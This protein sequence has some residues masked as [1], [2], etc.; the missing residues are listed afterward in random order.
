MNDA[1][2]AAGNQPD[3]RTEATRAMLEAGER[4]TRTGSWQWDVESD[5]FCCSPGWLHI[6]GCHVPPRSMSEFEQVMHPD[7]V[8]AVRETLQAVLAG[9]SPSPFEHRIIRRGEVR[10]VRAHAQLLPRADCAAR[11][12]IGAIQDITGGAEAAHPHRVATVGSADQAIASPAADR[13]AEISASR[14]Q[15]RILSARLGL[16]QRATTCSLEELLVATLDEVCALTGSSLGFYHFLGADQQTLTLQAWSTQTSRD[17]CRA[18]GQ[19]RHYDVAEAGVWVECIRLRCPVMHNDYAALPHRR[20]LPQG[21]ATLLRE[22]VVPIFRNGLIVAIL[23]VGNKAEPYGDED[24]TTVSQ[25]ADLAWDIAAAKQADCQIR[26]S[27]ERLSGIVD[28]ALDAIVTVD[29][30][31][32][33]VLFNA[34][35]EKMFQC[36][37]AE[38]L[39]KSLDRFIPERFRTIHRRQVVDFAST[40]VVSRPMGKTRQVCGVRAGGEEF[41]IEASISQVQVRGQ[42]LFTV[43]LRDITERQQ[44]QEALQKGQ[45]FNVAVIDSLS[46]HVAVLD[47]EGKITAVNRAWRQFAADNGGTTLAAHPTGIDYRQ[48]CLSA[49]GPSAVEALAAWQ[50]IEAVLA[51]HLPLFEMEYT[52]HSPDEEIWFRMKVQPLQG[53]CGGVVVTHEDVTR[54]RR[55]ANSLRSESQR[56][57]NIIEGTNVGTWEWNVQT[58]EATVNERW[59]GIIGYTLAE[60]SPVSIATWRRFAHPDD[61]ER[62]NDLAERHFAGAL[63][64]YDSECR[65]RHKHGHWV[66]VRDRGKV[67]DWTADGKPLHMFGTHL[68]VTSEKLAEQALL[69]AIEFNKQIIAGAQEG[70]VVY[71][72]GLRCQVWNPYL[73][74]LTGLPAQQVIGSHPLELF[75]FLR[76]TGSIARLEKALTGKLPGSTE[77]PFAVSQTGRTGWVSGCAAPLHDTHGQI[78]G[79]IATVRDI[80][81]TKRA[82]EA[83]REMNET[84]E[85]RVDERTRQLAIATQIAESAN[86]AKSF[87]LANMSHEI[88]TPMTAILGLAE[89]LNLDGVTTRQAERLKKMNHAARHL[90]GIIDDVLDLSKIEAG[91]LVLEEAACDV[92]SIV[93][94]VVEITTDRARQKQIAL[95]TDCESIPGQLRGDP[96]RIRQALLNYVSNAIR[97]TERGSVTVRVRCQESSGDHLLLRF[98]VQ[99]TGIGIAADTIGRLFQSFEQADNSMTREYGGTGLGLAIVKQIAQ[100]M[101]GRAGVE[102]CEGTGSTFWF[103]ARLRRLIETSADLAGNSDTVPAVTV[104]AVEERMRQEKR[105]LLVDDERINREVILA[106]LETIGMKADCAANGEEAVE[107]A[108]S[109]SYDLILMDLQMPRMDGLEATRRIRR[110]PINAQVPVLALT[111]NVSTDVKGLCLAAGMND[112]IAKPFTVDVLLAVVDHWLLP[113]TD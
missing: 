19:G 26:E 44:A 54:S 107:L 59:A 51:G 108:G 27:Q 28:A 98:E 78:I 72:H 25:L 32:R 82:A 68:D 31:Y 20:G 45:A 91:K 106:I 34:A 75:P 46:A 7:D 57:A 88:R 81:E 30:A 41:P 105:I 3:Y 52:C 112:F 35:A 79:V 16:M 100:M 33:I 73:E 6:H 5:A 23:G 61:L 76:E 11:Q 10:V 37:A 109:L 13:I 89:L 29:E 36:A 56:L 2:I 71:D 86:R 99:D 93:D 65:M 8:A 66:W 84:L 1:E 111:G 49:T 60:I 12:V 22:L 101:D 94:S 15:E 18:E 102:S 74:N 96:I 92:A 43:A 85:A 55:L 113:G 21:H 69:E 83:L 39:G 63:T 53:D 104:E 90:L 9:K 70:I 50:G 42:R 110:L 4:L 17:Y 47:R 48:A 103:T 97:F 24:L 67:M 87:F 62:S 64:H 77:F 38:T 14:L 80:T 58:G 40:P 95:L